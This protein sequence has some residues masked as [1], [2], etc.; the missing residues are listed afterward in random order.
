M[1]FLAL[2]FLLVTFF[3]CKPLP[4]ADAMREYYEL[5]LYHFS[6][7]NQEQVID[8]YLAKALLPALHKLNIKDVGIFKPLANDTARD[9]LIYVLVPLRKAEQ[10]ASLPNQLLKDKQYLL[11]GKEYL[12]APYNNAPYLRLE[13]MLLRAFPLAPQM[14]LPKLGSP[15]TEHIYEFRSYESATE[16]LYRN[17]VKMFNEG[18]EIALFERLQ[19]NAIFYA[20]VITGGRMPNLVYMTSFENMEERDKHWKTFVDD[21]EWKKLSGMAEYKNNV[22]KADIILMKA[23]AYSDY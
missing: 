22:S 13:R 2:C 17:K 21:A 11:A 9:K 5:T 4:A 23:T 20:E 12:E 1:K 15:K 7:A 3:L 6:S 10:I 8:N 16:K 14:K 19:F 18:G